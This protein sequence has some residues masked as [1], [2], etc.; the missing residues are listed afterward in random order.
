MKLPIYSL[1]VTIWSVILLLSANPAFSLDYY[2]D[3]VNGNDRNNGRSAEFKG[4]R[5]GPWKSLN[6]AFRLSGQPK[7]GPEPGYS[8][9]Y[10][11]NN[12]CT[13]WLMDGT[14]HN[15]GTSV[16]IKSTWLTVRNY[17][18]HSPKIYINP[19]QAYDRHKAVTVHLFWSNQ[20][21]TL[22][23]LDIGGGISYAL[24]ID[25]NKHHYNTVRNCKIHGSGWAGIKLVGGDSRSRGNKE[26]TNTTIEF[27]EIYD[28]GKRD[29]KNAQGIDGN[30]ISDSIIRNNYI[31]DITA[32]GLYFKGNC[33]RITVEN[34]FLYN[35]GTLSNKSERNYDTW[36]GIWLGE[37]MD[38][39]YI[40]PPPNNFEIMN[41]V[42]RNNIIVNS[43]GSPLRFMG[44]KNCSF[45]RNTVYNTNRTNS[46]WYD[47][48]DSGALTI[49]IS[50]AGSPPRERNENLTFTHNL[51]IDS[52][53]PSDVSGPCD[54]LDGWPN[55]TCPPGHG[56]KYQNQLVLVGSKAWT[57]GKTTSSEFKCDH[58]LYY[59]DNPAH[60]LWID[61]PRNIIKT[62]LGSWQAASGLDRNSIVA[63]SPKGL[64][65]ILDN[66]ALPA[67]KLT[68]YARGEQ[69]PAGVG[70]DI[71]LIQLRPKKNNPAMKSK[72]RP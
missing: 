54:V 51:I 49:F 40:P 53:K 31:H 3:P 26:H 69:V 27:C 68:S 55:N 22:D 70:A 41:S 39:H 33:N 37:S 52:Q 11:K 20:H 18:G 66:P 72:R 65:A 16:L 36:G 57:P 60:Y 8:K 14:H 48:I 58:N 63:K 59:R 43:G 42:A 29:P 19:K 64:I 67:D 7:R 35:V 17:P 28:I 9:R 13:I 30:A 1:F 47:Y 15:M 44:A 25:S 24:K 10:T 56:Q 12:P 2:I 46:P 61:N 45:E 21:V 71:R 50:S 23:G 32:T 62:T 5:S 6:Q 38:Q 34:N 4:G